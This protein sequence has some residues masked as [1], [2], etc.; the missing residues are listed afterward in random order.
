MRFIVAVL[1]IG[2]TFGAGE[3]RAKP[4]EDTSANPA[5]DLWKKLTAFRTES[6][7]LTDAE[8]ATQWLALLD[9]FLAFPRDRLIRDAE[10]QPR[11][12]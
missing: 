9:A 5:G 1:V 12:K 2:I 6:P 8:A 4:P 11:S 7:K 10:P 3:A